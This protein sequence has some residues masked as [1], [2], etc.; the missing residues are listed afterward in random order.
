MLIISITLKNLHAKYELD[1]P[2][3]HALLVLW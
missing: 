3:S 2:Y 1:G